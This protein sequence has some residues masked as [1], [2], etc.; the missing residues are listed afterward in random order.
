MN[1]YR[2]RSGITNLRLS[3]MTMTK[4][5]V[6]KNCKLKLTATTI[7]GTCHSI[8]NQCYAIA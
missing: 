2:D 6:S 1:V 4:G 3:E 7:N 8:F 5:L